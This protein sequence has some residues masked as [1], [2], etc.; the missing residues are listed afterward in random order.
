MRIKINGIEYEIQKDGLKF[1]SFIVI[2]YAGGEE[3]LLFLAKQ[4]GFS[5]IAKV[6][7]KHCKSTE[8]EVLKLMEEGA[9]I[10]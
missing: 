7:A 8:F 10:S 5:Q 6:I 9:K 4:K 2:Q 3:D 1:K